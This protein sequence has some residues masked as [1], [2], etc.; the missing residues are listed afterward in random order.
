MGEPY[1]FLSLSQSMPSAVVAAVDVV[2]IPGLT[3]REF[4]GNVAT[5]DATLSA[6]HDLLQS[7]QCRILGDAQSL[8]NTF[9]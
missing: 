7:Q 6:V 9:P 1:S 3:I 5:K 2:A 8:P 4:F